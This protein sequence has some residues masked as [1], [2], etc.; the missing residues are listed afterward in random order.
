MENIRP[1]S[2]NTLPRDFVGVGSIT[3]VPDEAPYCMLQV[4]FQSRSLEVLATRADGLTERPAV[5]DRVLCASSADGTVYITM[6]L[7]KAGQ[8]GSDGTTLELDGETRARVVSRNGG[9]ILAVHNKRGELIFEYDPDSDRSRVIMASGGLDVAAPQGDIRFSA[10][11]R[12]QLE[13]RCVEMLAGGTAGTQESRLSLGQFRT[14]LHSASLDIK[15][16]RSRLELDEVDYVGKQL[17]SRVSR[18]KLHWGRLE[19]LVDTLI[20][21]ARTSFT[22][23]EELSQTRAGRMRMLVAGAFRLKAQ[24]AKLKTDKNVDI[25]GERI[26]LG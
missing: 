14:E 19:T 20:Q 25:D 23:V 10:G 24:R 6:I 11:G 7:E 22:S 8:T 9:R 1:I 18:G 26:N 12:I 3:S 2:Q 17:S 15:S 4:V 21:K 13:S 5:G 16:A